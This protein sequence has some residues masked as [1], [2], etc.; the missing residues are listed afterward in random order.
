MDNLQWETIQYEKANGERPL[1]DFLASLPIKAQEK[2]IR[3]IEL[4]ERFG[5]RW[6][7]PHV[8][9]LPAHMSYVQSKYGSNIYRTFF[10]RWPDTVLVLTSGYHKKAQKMDTK[11]FKQAQPFKDD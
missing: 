3:D 4:L 1:F 2:V 8:R 9:S 5:P 6:G 11:K 7:M 10:L